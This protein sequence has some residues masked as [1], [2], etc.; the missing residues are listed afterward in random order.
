[1]E[2]SFLRSL[3]GTDQTPVF[4]RACEMADTVTDKKDMQVL[5]PDVLTWMQSIFPPLK[6]C[7]IT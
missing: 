5:L 6:P 3:L 7:G 1:M 4:S 2:R